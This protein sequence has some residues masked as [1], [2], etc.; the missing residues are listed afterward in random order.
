MTKFLPRGFVAVALILLTLIVVPAVT[1]ASPGTGV[2]GTMEFMFYRERGTSTAGDSYDYGLKLNDSKYKNITLER[3][4]DYLVS[5]TFSAGQH[6][7]TVYDLDMNYIA[8]I[9][10]S[11]GGGA[12]YVTVAEGKEI[13][14]RCQDGNGKN[15][16]YMYYL[17]TGEITVPIELTAQANDFWLIFLRGPE[18]PDPIYAYGI[19]KMV[20]ESAPDTLGNSATGWANDISIDWGASAWYRITVSAWL[21]N[22]GATKD[23]E[24][25]VRVVDPILGLDQV[26]VFAKNEDG[27]YD[28][29]VL[30]GEALSLGG[31]MEDV[32]NVAAIYE[33]EEGGD[34]LGEDDADVYVII[35]DPVYS[36]SIIKKVSA[37]DPEG[38]GFDEG[39]WVDAVTVDAGS[40]V[41]YKVVI[42]A[43]LDNA[44]QSAQGAETLDV[45]LV[46]EIAGISQSVTLALKSAGIYEAVVE[47][48]KNG[49]NGYVINTAL[50]YMPDGETP[51][52]QDTAEVFVRPPHENEYEYEYS[53]IKKVSAVDPGSEG[54]SDDNWKDEVTVDKGATVW[55]KIVVTA[56]SLADEGA[57][58]L[59]VLLVDPEFGI[60]EWVT[61]IRQTDD[62]DTYS[63]S[64]TIYA[65]NAEAYLKNVAEIYG[66]DENFLK[67]DDATVNIRTGGGGGD[68]EEEGGGGGGGGGST[69]TIPDSSVPK[70]DIPT[71]EVPK[72]DLPDDGNTLGNLPVTGSLALTGSGLGILGSALAGALGFVITRKKKK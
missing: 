29:I 8:T 19:E 7:W 60:N 3:H 34:F 72:A 16:V 59:S 33:P 69:S 71:T 41:W 70:V 56:R 52:G 4:G 40:D 5:N 43:T 13:V 12:C 10:T 36:Y 6:V 48:G 23:W 24:L 53:V 65:T 21:E 51:L 68:D 58:S 49:I 64:H 26:V 54:F 62:P 50:I 35:P 18:I 14:I 61:L 31:I 25:R 57:E 45:W 11:N 63:Y 28:D 17:F 27:F 55:F 37:S 44:D 20:S 9:Q 42:S 1:L 47:Y 66:D 67:R 39:S 32:H 2:P 15:V 46:D 22:E 30:Y 38:E